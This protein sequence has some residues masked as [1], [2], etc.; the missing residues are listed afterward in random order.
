MSKIPSDDIL[1]SLYKLRIRESA[2]LKTVVELNDVEVHQK[3]SMPT[4][5]KLKTM[6]KRRIDQRLRLRNFD[7]RHGRLESGAV[8]TSHREL[9]GVER[10]KGVCYQWKEKGQCS[11][12]DPCSFRHESNDHAANSSSTVQMLFE[13]YFARDRLVN[14][15]ILPSVNSTKQKRVGKTGDKCM[16]PHHKVDEQP[17][18]KPKKGYCSH[19]RRG[20]DDKN[21]VAIVKI[22]PQF[23]CVSQD[24]ESLVSQKG[25]QSKTQNTK[26]RAGFVC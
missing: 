23:G 2:Q 4:Y 18:E 11:N 10:G 14:I 9:S 19:K 17:N 7:A 16:F 12:G 22:V 8:A 1:E 6:V 13:S 5:Q 25:K 26:E 24:S 3:I 15:G 21:A 20:S